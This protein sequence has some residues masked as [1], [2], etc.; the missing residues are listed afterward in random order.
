MQD[1]VYLKKHCLM[2]QEVFSTLK[3]ANHDLER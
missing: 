1:V 3:N 2:L